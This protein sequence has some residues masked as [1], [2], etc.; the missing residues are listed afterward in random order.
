MVNKIFYKSLSNLDITRLNQD[1]NFRGCFMR[2][3]LKDISPREKESGVLNLDTSENQG[4]HWTCWIK[5]KKTILYFDSFGLIPPPEIINFFKK[6]NDYKGVFYNNTI[7]QPDNT[8]I[9]G[10]LCLYIINKKPKNL[11][12][13]K[14]LIL[15]LLK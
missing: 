9:C 2:D 10:H 1:P 15:N 12:S 11:N 7:I 4:T 13:F 5:N 6:S 3:E 8:V 14:S